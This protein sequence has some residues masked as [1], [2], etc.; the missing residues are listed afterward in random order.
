MW[1]PEDDYSSSEKL[2]FASD[3]GYYR[4]PHEVKVWTI[5]DCGMPITTWDIYNTPFHPRLREHCEGVGSR[6]QVVRA[7]APAAMLRLLSSRHNRDAAPSALSD[8]VAFMGPRPSVSHH[9]HEEEDTNLRGR[10]GEK[11]RASVVS[12]RRHEASIQNSGIKFSKRSFKINLK[13]MFQRAD[14]EYL[15][16]GLGSK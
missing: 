4:G 6:R 13:T 16:N 5:M 1:T 12:D 2:H 8:A 3:R 7:G 9:S 14:S 10:H 11:V 15:M